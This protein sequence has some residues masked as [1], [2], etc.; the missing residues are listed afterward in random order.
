MLEGV[1][2]Y[3]FMH[4]NRW[5]TIGKLKKLCFLRFKGLQLTVWLI[6]P[7]FKRDGKLLLKFNFSFNEIL[8]TIFNP[9]CIIPSHQ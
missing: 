4:I 2:L 1:F 8:N 6:D 7:I 3:N 5:K 9:I